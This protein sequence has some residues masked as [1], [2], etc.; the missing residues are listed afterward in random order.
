MNVKNI[1]LVMGLVFGLSSVM[2][3]AAQAQLTKK[4]KRAAKLNRSIAKGAGC[5]NPKFKPEKHKSRHAKSKPQKKPKNNFGASEQASRQISMNGKSKSVN[6][7]EY[8]KWNKKGDSWK[9][10]NF[11]KLGSQ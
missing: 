3:V 4:Q 5:E 6:E 1:G 2:P 9:A 8:A 10:K 7:K 11:E